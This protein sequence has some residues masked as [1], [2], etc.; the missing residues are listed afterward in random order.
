MGAASTH[1]TCVGDLGNF[2]S[3]L[4]LRGFAGLLDCQ[5]CLLSVLLQA[6]TSLGE[7]AGRTG[8]KSIPAE[9]W[10]NRKFGLALSVCKHVFEALLKSKT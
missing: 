4:W 10:P 3:L 8:F 2:R 6:Q 9:S 7:G 5:A 1:Y